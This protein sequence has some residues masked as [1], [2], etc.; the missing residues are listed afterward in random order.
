MC[1]EEMEVPASEAAVSLKVTPPAVMCF[2]ERYEISNS[3]Y[4][5]NLA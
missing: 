4:A 2:G 1:D 3:A 5:S